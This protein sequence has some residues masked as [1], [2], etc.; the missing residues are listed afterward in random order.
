MFYIK[1][2]MTILLMS[3]AF[4]YSINVNA[5]LYVIVNKD[6]PVNSISR[7]NLKLIYLGKIVNVSG[8]RQVLYPIELSS[9]TIARSE[10]RHKVIQMKAS[11]LMQYRAR[12]IFSGNRRVPREVFSSGT[13]VSIVSRK[14]NSIGY[15]SA[16]PN[17]SKVKTILIL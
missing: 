16:P 12:Q 8:V 4:F 5:A 15:V 10:F 14:L 1:N 13:V 17:S 2:L 11:Q 6:N 7:E 9:R 3:M